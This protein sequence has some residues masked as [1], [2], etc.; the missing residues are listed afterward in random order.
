MVSLGAVRKSSTGATTWRS[1]SRVKPASMV[2]ASAAVAPVR[3]ARADSIGLT[4]AE[5]PIRW[6]RRPAPP[7]STSAWRRSSESARWAPRFDPIKAWISSTIR[8]R[9]WASA[10]RNRSLVN[11]I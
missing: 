7:A 3:K 11:K 8:N 1:R 6:G 10:G 5:Q 2:T 9:V 4:V